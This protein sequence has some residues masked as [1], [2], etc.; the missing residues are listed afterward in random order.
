MTISEF[1]KMFEKTGMKC[2][3]PEVGSTFDHNK[4]EAISRIESDIEIGSIVKVIRVGY[5][6]YGRLL[7]PAMV[8][9]SSGK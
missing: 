8:V 5:E 9:V 4:H 1:N 3:N 7:R 6:I 2:I